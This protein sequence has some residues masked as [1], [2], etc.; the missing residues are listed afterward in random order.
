LP[1]ALALAL[2][3]T[4]PVTASEVPLTKQGGVYAV[5]VQINGAI[6]LDF[7]VDSGAAEVNI[8]ADVVMT[9]I[10]AK[11]IV[12]S[13]F[14]PGGTYV[15]ADGT[16]LESARFTIRLVRIGDHVIQNVSAS[17]GDVTSHLLLGQSVL[18]R[19][20]RWSLD[21]RRGVMVLGEAG[22]AKPTDVPN[23]QP[24][25]AGPAAAEQPYLFDVLKKPGYKAGWNAMMKGQRVDPWLTAFGK[26]GGGVASPMEPISSGGVDYLFG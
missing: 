26:G 12:L 14:L 6:T 11:T 17:I 23:R 20:G 22:D 10:R 13:D 21:S 8:P 25:G 15:L 3:T 5:P 16:R 9:L 1:V 19:L 18:E 2:S 4:P 24:R 7:I